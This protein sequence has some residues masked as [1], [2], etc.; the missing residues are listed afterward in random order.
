MYEHVDFAYELEFMDG[1]KMIVKERTYSRAIVAGA[2]E[3]LLS[4]CETRR[5]LSLVNG[6]RRTD[7]D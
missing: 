6:T 3:R 5:Q 1:H 7:I 4:G 2:Y